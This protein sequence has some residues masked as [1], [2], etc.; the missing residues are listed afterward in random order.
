MF[1]LFDFFS[2]SISPISDIFCPNISIID[3]NAV[4]PLSFLSKSFFNSDSFTKI[5][6][7]LIF[8][9]ILL[10]KSNKTMDFGMEQN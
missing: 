6:N 10:Q 4:I 8:S 1:I 3:F 2:L 9:L 7:L 5:N